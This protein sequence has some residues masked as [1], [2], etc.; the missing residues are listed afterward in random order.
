MARVH[1]ISPDEAQFLTL[2]RELPREKVVEL[3]NLAKV[4]K[5][6]AAEKREGI[7][8]Q[9][10]RRLPTSMIR[11]LEEG[12]LRIAHYPIEDLDEKYPR[13]KMG[14]KEFRESLS[15]TSIPIEEYIRRERS[16]GGIGGQNVI[17]GK[18]N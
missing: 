15:R 1:V 12:R 11:M 7:A 14:L 6:S 9:R 5:V 10:L 8:A 2:I 13:P 4:M 17:Y 18:S 16:R 3:I